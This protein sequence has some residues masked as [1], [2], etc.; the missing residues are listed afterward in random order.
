MK[1]FLWS[2]VYA[3]LLRGKKGRQK[4][5]RGESENGDWS[6][7]RI[8][9]HEQPLSGDDIP[10]YEVSKYGGQIFHDSIWNTNV[11][12]PQRD[13]PFLDDLEPTA[14]MDRLDS[15]P[16]NSLGNAPEA[17]GGAEGNKPSYGLY[18]DFV[19][20]QLHPNTFPYE[21]QNACV[22]TT[23]KKLEDRHLVAK[24]DIL[25][26]HWVHI[27]DEFKNYP[28]VAPEDR[29]VR[30]IFGWATDPVPIAAHDRVPMEFAKY[31]QQVY[32]KEQERQRAKKT[33]EAYKMADTSNDDS[34]D[35][36]EFTQEVEK[37]Q[38]KTKEEA[39]K[40]WN[41]YKLPDSEVMTAT[42]YGKIVRDGFDLGSVSLTR[43]LRGTL[44]VSC[45]LNFG[46]WTG[47]ASCPGD[48]TAVGVRL[49]VQEKVQ[50]GDN[51][52]LNGVELRCVNLKDNSG[53]EDIKTMEGPDG[54]YSD[55]GTCPE[56]T[57][58]AGFRSRTQV[59]QPV[60]D[61]AGVTDFAFLCK[62]KKGA[63]KMQI[64]FGGDKLKKEEAKGIDAGYVQVVTGNSADFGGWATGDSYCPTGSAICAFQTRLEIGQEAGQNMG[65]TNA[66]FFCCVDPNIQ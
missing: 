28:N 42:E 24:P 17:P 19:P 35:W 8:K 13:F 55:W 44:E 31:F 16:I 57:Y 38:K 54:K 20:P 60:G 6:A 25:R 2:V 21:S 34:I 62:D 1:F 10:G 11:W 27:H 39:Q 26:P 18:G 49:K 58:I 4:D 46:F 29:L 33:Y 22:D 30:G 32:N 14:P 15:G 52:G 12:H 41:S 53:Q 56:G 63:K 66:R 36:D 37:R 9:A 45:G 47:S 43:T 65:V 5:G 23:Q 48:T 40:L 59:F 61:N 3:T 64:K 51:T 7:Q 50:D